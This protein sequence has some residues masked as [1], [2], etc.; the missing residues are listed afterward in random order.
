MIAWRHKHNSSLRPKSALHVG[1]KPA[2][3]APEPVGRAVERPLFIRC[4]RYLSSPA[5]SG[6]EILRRHYPTARI[7]VR[8]G[9]HNPGSVNRL[10]D[11]SPA[12]VA[13]RHFDGLHH[14]FP[15]A[16]TQRR[17]FQTYGDHAV[18]G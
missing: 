18:L 6:R 15:L 10:G 12:A 7:Q 8:I 11:A 3:A 4:R 9:S 16:S 14:G 2:K 17:T 5:T 1:T 13:R